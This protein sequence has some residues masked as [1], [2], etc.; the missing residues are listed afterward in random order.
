MARLAP[1]LKNLPDIMLGIESISKMHD[2]QDI[3]S[4]A[5]D[6][7]NQALAHDL[8]QIEYEAE[9]VHIQF[10]TLRRAS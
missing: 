10:F 4:G 9:Q 8:D 2:V 7:M 6:E 5:A 1:T 3:I